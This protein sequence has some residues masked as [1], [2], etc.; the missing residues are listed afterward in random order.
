MVTIRNNDGK[1]F[2]ARVEIEGNAVILHSRSGTSRNRDYRPTLEMILARLADNGVKPD[3][4]LDSNRVEHLPLLQRRILQGA[5]LTGTVSE[6]FSQ[7]IRAM[8]AGRASN[9]AWSKVRLIADSKSESELRAILADSFNGAST[10]PGEER[11]PSVLQRRVRPADIKAAV[12]DIL[13]GHVMSNF[14]PSTDYDLLTEQ[15]DLLAP[16]HVFGRALEIAGIVAKARPVHFS[17]GWSQPCFPMLEEAGYT[18]IT[19]SASAAEAQRRKRRVARSEAETDKAVAS[20]PVEPEERRWIEGNPR[21]AT[22][23]RI[24]RTRSPKAAISKRAAIR[25]A[26]EGHLVCEH[27]STDWYAVYPHG[28]AEAIFDIHHTVPLKDMGEDHETRIE[29]LLCLCANCH[30]AEHRRMALG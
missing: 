22:H 28:I 11:L 14:G 8:N 6:Q 19:K 4:Y 20:V 16:K 26:N 9:G 3:I 2:D 12:A 13:A 21:M 23:L 17:A 18:I 29:E 7:L 30:R 15:G 24:E 25:A 1:A 27:C 10:S 5:Q